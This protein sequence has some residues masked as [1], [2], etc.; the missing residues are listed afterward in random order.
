MGLSFRP[1]R[2]STSGPLVRAS[3]LLALAMATPSLSPALAQT[4]SRPANAQTDR[5]FLQ[6]QEMIYNRDANT[7]EARGQV[8]LYYQGR[9]LQADRVVYDRDRE[10][11]FAQGNAKLTEQDGTVSY[12]N[13][14]ELT[15]D[16]K[17]GFVDSLRIDTTDQSFLTAAR[18]ERLNGNVNVL[19]RGTYT[20]CGPCEDNPSKPPL[21]Q[22]RAKRIVHNKDE[23]TVYY[24]DASLELMGMPVAWFPF[25][26]APDAEARRKSGILA[27]RYVARSNL[28]VGVGAPI[29]WALAPN[30]DLTVTPMLYS[31]QG[32]FLDTEWRHQ[33]INGAYRVRLS[34]IF[35]SDPKTFQPPPNGPGNDR[36]R[37][38]LETAGQFLLNERWRFGWDITLLSDRWFLQDYR[39][40]ISS[41]S[42]NYF[43]EAISSVYLNGQSDRAYFDAR[44]YYFQGLSR[45]DLQE[46]Q[47]IVAPVVDYNKTIDIDP[48][49]NGIGGQIEIDANMTHLTRALAAYEA[50]GPRSLTGPG[51]Y[52]LYSYCPPT[53]TRDNCI[54]R[55]M[56]GNY[57]RTTLNLSWKQQFIDAAGQVWTPF[58]FTRVNGA[59]TTLN[60]TNEVAF[61][62]NPSLT[63]AE[64]VALFG[65][66][67]NSWLGQVTPGVGVEYR[68]PFM[69]ASSFGNQVI[70]P[71]VQI[72]SRPNELSNAA[73]VNEDS[74]SLVFDD[75]NLFMW[76]KFSGYDRFEGGTR[77][78]Y[79]AQYT[80]TLHNGGYAN[81]M[82]GQSYQLAGTNSYATADAAHIGISSGL[83]RRQSDLVARFG[84]APNSFTSFMVKGR[85]DP[86]D[87]TMRRLDVAASARFSNRLEGSL[88]YARYEAQ[89]YIGYDKRREGIST[90]L[91]YKFHENYYA[92]GNVIFDL[93]RHLYN[94]EVGGHAGLFSLAGVG[95]GIGY[96]DDCTTLAVNYASVYQDKGTGTP[97][98]NQ[99][100]LVQLQLRT[101]GDT[102]VQSSLSAM[103]VDDGLGGLQGP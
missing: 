36:F 44:A 55:G 58:M 97:V 9:I 22:V 96:M 30:Y 11:V 33:L 50:V 7:I 81:M 65:R 83:D 90:A 95:G 29:F 46:Q 57:T 77:L 35:Q 78:N 74:Q 32:L 23:Q 25:F 79:G 85:F 68:F 31:Q 84:L 67:A 59:F 63:N 19:E 102:R 49:K 14:I 15:D 66:D 40:P 2:K 91:K 72:I 24:E 69:A 61:A 51:S 6:A 71:I 45:Y 93:S 20:A 60:R 39:M 37:G 70:E 28:G 4:A 27:P 43:R 88:Q 12:G 98:R 80:L 47:P 5:L 101:L 21:W 13:R 64:Q 73:L 26:S 56:G 48:R 94:I 92:S 89:P 99:T 54:V 76:N 1:K 10:R 53:V 87:M 3:M 82:L 34:G 8:Q 52:Q 62:G 42:S 17:H 16:F 41:L 86:Q 38:S 18:A 75:T 100:V 103:R